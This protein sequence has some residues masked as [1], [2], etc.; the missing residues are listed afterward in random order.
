MAASGSG[1][2]ADFIKSELAGRGVLVEVIGFDYDRMKEF[3]TRIGAAEFAAWLS[4]SVIV[5]SS[6]FQQ[7]AEQGRLVAFAL[8]HNHY[9]AIIPASLSS[10]TASASTASSPV[11]PDSALTPPASTAPIPAPSVDDGER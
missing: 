6:K 8:S 9:Y 1:V 5:S 3:P 7:A 4:A 10:S 2:F 11:L